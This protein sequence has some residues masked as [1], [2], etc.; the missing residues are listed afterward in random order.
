M[1]MKVV[2]VVFRTGHV[3]LRLLKKVWSI[4]G[5]R[6]GKRRDSKEVQ[7]AIP[8]VWPPESATTSVGLNPFC[9][10]EFNMVVVLAKGGGRLASVTFIVAKLSPS[11]LPKGML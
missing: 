1:S 10:R 5:S 4:V 2:L 6:D 9:A 8:M 3:F 11:R 7:W